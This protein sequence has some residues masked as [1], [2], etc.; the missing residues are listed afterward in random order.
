[1]RGRM[2]L[3]VGLGNPGTQ[4]QWTRHNVGFLAIDY[5]A[6]QWKV[7]NSNLKKKLKFI[8]LALMEKRF[9]Y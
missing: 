4:Y 6:T 7:L 5:I 8:L 3:V 1:M 9:C 2:K